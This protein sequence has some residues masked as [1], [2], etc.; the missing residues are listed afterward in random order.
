[1]TPRSADCKI[2][3]YEKGAALPKSFGDLGE[4]DASED[5]IVPRRCH[6]ER[7]REAVR[8]AACRAGADAA[9][10]LSERKP[11]TVLNCWRIE[12]RLLKYGDL[13]SSLPLIQKPLPP[14]G[15][16]PANIR[17]YRRQVP[18]AAKDE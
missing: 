1:M 10:I 15:G 2:D 3:W 12:A 13:P 4:V 7:V 18:P 16:L 6:K 14:L 11:N 9:V 17:Q 5:R 8:E